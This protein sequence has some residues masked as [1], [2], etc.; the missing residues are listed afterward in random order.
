MV[1]RRQKK[2]GE[3]RIDKKPV[4]Y[5]NYFDCRIVYMH[6]LLLDLDKGQLYGVF[7]KTIKKTNFLQWAGLR[8]SIPPHLKGTNKSPSITALKFVTEYNVFDVFD[9]KEI[10]RLLFTSCRKESAATLCSPYTAKKF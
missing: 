10:K 8:H 9:G 4:F 1:V 2:I 5:K 6:N 7:S 3:I